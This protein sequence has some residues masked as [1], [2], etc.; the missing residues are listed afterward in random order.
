[1]MH[2]FN[3][4]ATIRQAKPYKKIAKATHEHKAVRN[5]LNRNFS[6]GETEESS[7]YRYYLRLLWFWTTS[8]SI[9]CR[10]CC[11]M[12]CQTFDE[13]HQLIEEYMEAYNTNRYQWSLNRMTPAQ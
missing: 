4:K 10:R 6:Q 1:I 11:Y 9:L 13:L 3:L 5:H 7:P 12:E 8:F 2:K